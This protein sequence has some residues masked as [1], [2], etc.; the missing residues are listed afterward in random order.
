MQHD[1]PDD[2]NGDVL[3]RMIADG[4]NLSVPREIDFSILFP[5]EKSAI[6]FARAVGGKFDRIKILLLDSAM[7]GFDWDVTASRV[8]LPDHTEITEIEMF[9]ENVITPLGG[10]NDGW[11]CFQV[12]SHSDS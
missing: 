8:M 4:D 9:L 3:R 5:D 11:G 12:Q 2:M 1:I 6:R 7:R 10:E